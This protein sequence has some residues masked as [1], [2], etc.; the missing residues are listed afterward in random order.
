MVPTYNEANT[1]AA[2]QQWGRDMNDAISV[3]QVIDRNTFVRKLNSYCG[4][5]VT[6][7]IKPATERLQ[8][9]R[10]KF[11]TRLDKRLFPDIP[12]Y[13]VKSMKE[14]DEEECWND[15]DGVKGAISCRF[16]PHEEFRTMLDDIN[17]LTPDYPPISEK[18]EQVR[19][20]LG[21]GRLS[22]GPSISAFSKNMVERGEVILEE[23]MVGLVSFRILVYN[24][25]FRTISTNYPT[26]YP[27]TP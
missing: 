15:S 21:L 4:K 17:A 27:A 10:D 7:R 3:S 8:V 9:W 12:P 20:L 26:P 16:E 6:D 24:S 2:Y 25:R 13:P 18:M 1:A 19:T 11:E 22:V 14:L 5:A 23:I